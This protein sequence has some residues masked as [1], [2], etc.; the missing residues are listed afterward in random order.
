[1]SRAAPSVSPSPAL[2]RYDRACLFITADDA[3]SG[4]DIEDLLTKCRTQAQAAIREDNER[5]R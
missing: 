3:E 4:T 1:M 2:Q 5:S